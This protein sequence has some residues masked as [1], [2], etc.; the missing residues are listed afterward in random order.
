MRKIIKFILLAICLLVFLYSAYNIY[1]YLDEEN[2]NKQ[3]KKNLTE[4][5]VTEVV[6]DNDDVFTLPIKVDFLALKKENKDIIGWIYSEN[7]AINYPVV[8]SEDNEYYLRRLINGKHNTAGS[9]F[10]DFRSNPNLQDNNTII[11]GHNMKNGT[12]FASIHAYK[13]Q[14]YYNDHKVM[15]YF[16]PEKNYM[17]ELFAG[18]TISVNSDIYNLS[19]IDSNKLQELFSKSDFKS[20]VE[21]TDEDKILTLS[22][23]ADDYD[24]ARYIL[25]GV[26]R[27]IEN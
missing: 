10:M 14:E 3:L 20:N 7:T 17:I 5:V 1:K 24:G 12:M 2:A 9:I 6:T 25:M 15:Y 18:Y 19:G 8:Q 13:S 16:T 26:V 4:K 21:V 27:E 22:T 11:Y 23:C